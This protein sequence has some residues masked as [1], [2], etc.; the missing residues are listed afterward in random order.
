MQNNG[1]NQE[2][3]QSEEIATQQRA[4]MLG[5]PYIDSR[6]W[7]AQVE[8]IKDTL[9]KAEM[10]DFHAIPISIDK[11]RMTFAITIK[12][13]QTVIK[14][15][16]ARFPDYNV[17]YMAISEA[18]FKEIMLRHDPPQVIHYDDIS[19]KTGG[20]SETIEQVSQTLETVRSDDMLNYL[21][22]QAD[23]LGASDIHL[24][25]E[26]DYV[27]MRFRVDGA[28]HAIAKLS[29]DKFR[30]LNSSL[31][32]KSNISVAAGEPQT[33]HMVHELTTGDS[34]VR[35]LNMRIE[36]AST[37][38]GQ[39]AVIRMF[40][41]DRELMKLDNLGLSQ[42]LRAELDEIIR[43]PHGMVLVVGPT[44]SGKT[45]TLYSILDKLNISTRKIV[46]LEDP[47]EYSFEGVTQIPVNTKSGDES[48]AETLRGVLR[49]DPD[50]IMIGEIRDIDTAKT[51]L[52]ASLTGHLVLST[53]HAA[54]AA[55]AL[56]RMLDVIGDNPLFANAIRLIVAQRLVRR[57]DDATKQSYEPDERLASEINKIVERMPE[58]MTRPNLDQLKLYKPGTSS[59]IPFGYKGRLMIAEQLKMSPDIQKLL[60]QGPSGV[61]TKELKQLALE[62]GM[63]TL[64][65]DGIL[66]AVRGQTTVE[67]VYQNVDI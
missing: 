49:L 12:T 66:K 65:Q 16:R 20:A 17:S 67:E 64:I 40:S 46:T 54:D 60:L 45:T 36:T 61:T 53:F 43:H 3:R 37:A 13:S 51:A 22:T 44:G 10:Y 27:R 25:N 30:Q 38:Y 6:G 18:G 47:V 33:G 58:G 26:K 23:K 41:I 59:E 50:V 28:L 29:K 34:V 55:S 48:F 7:S 63:T 62:Q 14:Q 39:D 19:I 9:T 5:F 56:T 11:G 1:A 57:L 21:I 4:N 2:V 42:Q 32:I 31:A 24:E 52:Q 35:T 15:L 8:L